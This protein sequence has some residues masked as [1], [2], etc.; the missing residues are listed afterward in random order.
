MKVVLVMISYILQPASSLVL[1][2][3]SSLRLSSSS[4]RSIQP[5]LFRMLSEDEEYE[6]WKAKKLGNVKKLGSDENFGEYRRTESTIYAV[7]GLIT[8]LVPVI[9]GIWAYN[10]G[11]L[12]P[13]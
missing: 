4:A 2:P 6:I 5:R 8:V 10:E 11:Y 9:A 13:Q 1:I 7:G 3:T 12:T